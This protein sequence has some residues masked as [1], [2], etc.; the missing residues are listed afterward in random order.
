MRVD[1]GKTVASELNRLPSEEYRVLNDVLISSGSG[2]SQIDHIV[3]S[4]Y[5]IFVIE[6]K[7]YKGWIHGNEGSEYWIQSIYKEKTKFGNPI[8][9]NGAHVYALRRA[10]SA[11]EHAEY[12]PIVV[13]AGSAKLKNV[14]S[15]IPVI[16]D[17]QLV[18]TIME[19]RETPQLSV[20]QVNA[21]VDKLKSIMI[22]DKESHINH[23]K[24]HIWDKKTEVKATVCPRCGGSLVIRDGR[25]GKFYGCSSY[26]KCTYTQKQ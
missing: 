11:F 14:S 2:S 22:Q 23:V 15:K 16:Y 7:N 6:T 8:K 26:P 21:I 3:I 24:N 17:Y 20:A 13:F 9:Q 1:L 10:L 12:Y 18:Q 4:I 5:G 25:Y 19:H